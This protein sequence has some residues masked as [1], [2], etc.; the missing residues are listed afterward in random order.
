MSNFARVAEKL[1]ALADRACPNDATV[2]HQ[3]AASMRVLINRL[4]R[5]LVEQELGELEKVEPSLCPC[6]MAMMVQSAPGV[7]TCPRCRRE[8]VVW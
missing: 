2:L 8:E 6:G 7:L 1:D 5:L 4:A 3:A